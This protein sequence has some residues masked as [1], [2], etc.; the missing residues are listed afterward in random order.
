MADTNQL[1]NHGFANISDRLRSIAERAREVT[2]AR[3]AAVATFDSKQQVEHFVYA[4]LS[5]DVARRIGNPPKGRG[6]LG[7]LA[8]HEGP[9]RLDRIDEHPAS[10]GFPPHHPAMGPFLGVPL[11]AYQRTFGSLY[12][13]SEPG[14]APFTE[15]DE[16]AANVLALQVA[17]SLADALAA[18][19]ERRIARLEERGRIAHDLHDGTIQVLY[20][21]GLESSAF[22]ESP[23]V[24]PELRG[25]L[26]RHVER[27]NDLIA[28]IRSYIQGLEAQSPPAAPEISRDLAFIARSLIPDGIDTVVNIKAAALQHI[29]ARDAEDVLFIAREAVSNAVRHAQPSRIGIDLRNTQRE[30]VLTVQ[31]NGTGFDVAAARAG[32]GTI[33]MRTRARRLAA[34]LDIHS[35]PGMGTTVRLVLSQESEQ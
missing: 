19:Q 28:D 26:R 30:T 31:D 24:S 27:I 12:V 33:S 1:L 2:G 3:Y 32:M 6:L 29:G 17:G 7:V 13:A 34:S 21:M 10:V 16:L 18:E 22:A 5:D 35:I 14:A 9:L 20:A 11:R 15:D 4:G 8:G 23:E 25:L